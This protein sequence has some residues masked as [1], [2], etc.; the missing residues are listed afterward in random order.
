MRKSIHIRLGVRLTSSVASSRATPLPV[1]PRPPP[2]VLGTARAHRQLGAAGTG[3]RPCPRPAAPSSGFSSMVFRRNRSRCEQS[4]APAALSQLAVVPHAGS[5]G[6]PL[7]FARG[8]RAAE[9]ARAAVPRAKANLAAESAGTASPRAPCPGAVPLELILRDPTFRRGA[10]G[11]RVWG[12]CACGARVWGACADGAT[13]PHSA[14]LLLLRAT[15]KAE[16]LSSH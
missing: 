6:G 8:L 13:G 4:G 3:A 5:G 1:P 14:T 15:G 16:V 12:T 7:T 9:S 11:A 2:A 10:R